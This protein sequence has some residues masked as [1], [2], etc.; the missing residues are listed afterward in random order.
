MSDLR[1]YLLALCAFGAPLQAQDRVAELR[2]E[3]ARLERR[4]AR[5][6]ERQ[7][8]R[9]LA[10]LDRQQLVVI[11]AAPIQFA[12]P[13]WAA[14]AA[15]PRVAAQDSAWRR[16]FGGLVARVPA[17]TVRVAYP[18]DTSEWSAATRA[19]TRAGFV[20]RIVSYHAQAN[21]DRALR[22]LPP[23][24]IDWLGRDEPLRD[25]PALRVDAIV[26]LTRDSTG[27]GERCLTGDLPACRT[28]LE[29]DALGF[30]VAPVRQSFLDF[31]ID[32]T[33]PNGWELL[34]SGPMASPL[35]RIQRVTGVP[36]ERSLAEWNA[37]LR[38]PDHGSTSGQ[39]VPLFATLAWTIALALLA[40]GRARWLR[41]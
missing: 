7:R 9:G 13:A 33:D 38:R 17:E 35:L 19:L 5:L 30:R 23:D 4:E 40:L 8:E 18:A 1:T 36:L 25:F 11:G 3:V 26:A 27:I 32:G 16:R 20:D 10:S 37:A 22:A 39:G 15:A 12:V 21:S 31:A 14:P 29:R 6:S 41:V 28:F 34:A 24:L 2:A